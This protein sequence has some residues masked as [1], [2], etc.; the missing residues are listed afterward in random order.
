MTYRPAAAQPYRQFIIKIHSR[1]NLACDHCYVYTMVDQRWRGRPR[2]MTT[3]TIDILADRII[4]HTRTHRL[5]RADVIL[6][7]G[8]PLLAGRERIGYCIDRLRSASQPDVSVSIG[9]QTNGTLLDP[10]FLTMFRN[11]GV[12]VAVSLDGD[13]E[14]HDRHRVDHRGS[15]SWESVDAGLHL[16][17][18]PA[19]RGLLSGILCTVD[20]RNDPV[21][22]YEA[23]LAYRPPA[24]DL[25]LPHGNWSTPPLHRDGSDRTPYGDWL[26]AVFDRWYNAR[27]RETRIRLF[28]EILAVL[29][30]GRSRVESVGG[31]A[32]AVV[33]VETE[34]GIETSDML[35]AAYPGA[36]RTGFHIGANSFDEVLSRPA[37]SLADP[38]G[39]T[40]PPACRP[41]R[42]RRV[43][44]GGLYAHRYRQGSGFANPSVFC[45]D[46]YRL[47]TH[48]RSAAARDVA[49]MRRS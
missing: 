5:K 47:I 44:G 14:A 26:I 29:L 31:E 30:G 24:I 2:V 40:L 33:V 12:R 49:K 43:C 7:G 25:L 19:Y 23:L 9:V 1:C 16:L 13:R 3:K 8:E 45:R 46:L 37:S 21:A 38:P 11:H 27:T 10:A 39:P 34:G 6:H 28:D 36:G 17:N 15:G 18:S 48:I 41:C 32:P 20:I 4:E 42:V 35:T 22:T